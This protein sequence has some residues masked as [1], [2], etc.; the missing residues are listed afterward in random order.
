MT[1][2]RVGPTPREELQAAAKRWADQ[3]RA[4]LRGEQ[5]CPGCGRYHGTRVIEA[6][7]RDINTP[8]LPPAEQDTW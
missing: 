7:S 1:F 3:A 4:V 8:A 6:A 5:P 2:R